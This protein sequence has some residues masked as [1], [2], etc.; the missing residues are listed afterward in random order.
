MTSDSNHVNSSFQTEL[1]LPM[2]I[3]L[4]IASPMNYRP[5][6]SLLNILSEPTTGS[7]SIQMVGSTSPLIGK[8][9]SGIARLNRLLS[10]LLLNRDRNLLGF[11]L[12]AFGEGNL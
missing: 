7:S 2:I 10:N 6:F 5:D 9:G 12:A 1:P 4:C 8:P 3:N 11:N